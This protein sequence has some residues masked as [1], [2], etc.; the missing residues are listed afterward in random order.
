MPHKIAAGQW[1]KGGDMREGIVQAVCVSAVCAL[2]ALLSG[3]CR[4]FDASGGA[5]AMET[6]VFKC[7]PL[8]QLQFD[9]CAIPSEHKCFC[10][11]EHMSPAEKAAEREAEWKAFFSPQRGCNVSW[12]AGS[13]IREEGRSLIMTN[14]RFNLEALT[15][16]LNGLYLRG[17]VEIEMRIESDGT[18]LAEPRILTRDGNESV[19]KSVVEYLYPQD[20]DV[21]VETNSCAAVEPQNFTMRESGVIV[22]VVPGLRDSGMI[23]LELKVSHVGEP[24]WKDYGETLIAP[25]GDKYSLPMEQP[26]FPSRDIDTHLLLAPGVPV[27]IGDKSLRVTVVSRLVA[28]DGKQASTGAQQEQM[29]K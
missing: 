28:P 24:K 18:V 6:W 8:Q 26:I 21:M 16:W 2:T 22:D 11:G 20:Y 25:N 17:M 9:G 23:A 15:V 19:F 4:M 29:Q 5:E 7:E 13:G 1:Q 3:G 27:T 12:P 10:D 14:T